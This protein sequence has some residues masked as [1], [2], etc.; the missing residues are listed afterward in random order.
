[1]WAL[2][3]LPE[4]K[5]MQY[6]STPAL[7]KLKQR[8]KNL[9]RTTT[10]TH[11]Q[12]LDKAAQEIQ[13]KN[14]Y[15][16]IDANKA[17][18]P[19]EHAIKDG[20]IFMFDYKEADTVTTSQELIESPMLELLC[21][22]VFYAYYTQLRDPDDPQ[23]RKLLEIYSPDEIAADFRDDY[24]YV[25]FYFSNPEKMQTAQNALT[26]IQSH[27]FYLP[28]YIIFKGKVIEPDSLL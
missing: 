9:K 15:H 13:F 27:S 26:Y 28:R 18:L 2:S 16:V 8:A 6:I 25:F 23:H 5:I 10:L 3:V 24:S 19:L 17:Y 7:Q 14:W 11:T 4:G 20:C 22:T 21:E 1:M 12:A